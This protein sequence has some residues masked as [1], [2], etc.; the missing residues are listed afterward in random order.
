[1]FKSLQLSKAFWI[2]ISIVYSYLLFVLYVF[3][4]SPGDI[5]NPEIATQY[6]FA[7]KLTAVRLVVIV[8]GLIAYPVILSRFLK[9]AKYVTV[10]LTAWAFIMY[11]EDY[12]IL[13][14]MI[15]YPEGSSIDVVHL[16]RPIFIISL[17]WMCFE[18]IFI[19]QPRE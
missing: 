9:H 6:H 1:M 12:F 2:T 4:I 3:L 5:F 11:I 15:E 19:A 13:Y 16:L 10:A 17:I 8:F 7:M 14:S 18:L